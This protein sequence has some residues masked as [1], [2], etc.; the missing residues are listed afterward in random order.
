[1][2]PRTL[3]SK[4]GKKRLKSEWWKEKYTMTHIHT[5]T[6]THKHTHTHTHTHTL[7]LSLSLSLSRWISYASS[8]FQVFGLVFAWT[9]SHTVTHALS[10]THRHTDTT[11]HIQT[12][13]HTHTEQKHTH[14]PICTFSDVASF[15]RQRHESGFLFKLQATHFVCLWHP[16][17]LRKCTVQSVRTRIINNSL[18]VKKKSSDL[19]GFS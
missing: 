18:S 8:C 5:H 15:L 14:P 17:D 16:S 2:S 1:M 11:Q 3:L 10:H 7:S 19:Q 9:I 4:G 12:H 13:K 6:N